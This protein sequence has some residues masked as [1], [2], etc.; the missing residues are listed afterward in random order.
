[1]KTQIERIETMNTATHT[2]RDAE[3]K[4]FDV[5]ISPMDTINAIQ[6]MGKVPKELDL[7]AF[8]VMLGRMKVGS[9]VTLKTG[10]EIRRVA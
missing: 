1:M 4:L 6:E 10:L 2:I 9:G 7:D 3:G 5:G 8:E